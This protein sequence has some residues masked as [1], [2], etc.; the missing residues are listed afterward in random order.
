[1]PGP[2]RDTHPGLSDRSCT[3]EELKQVLR[4]FVSERHWQ[5]FHTAKNLSLSISIEAAELM[6]HFQWLTEK[7]VQ[8]AAYDRSEVTDELADVACY[9]LAM[10]NTL[11]IDLTEAIHRKMIKNRHK[12]P[13]PDQPSDVPW[14]E[15][16]SDSR[17]TD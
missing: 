9:V 16:K 3:V 15:R 7:E 10:A 5:R 17:R 2:V 14:S 13:V 1:M 11:D 6:E 4:D 12:Y 8:A